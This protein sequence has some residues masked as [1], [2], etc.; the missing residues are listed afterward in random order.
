MVT[1]T[2]LT[3]ST[4]WESSHF[5]TEVKIS[6]YTAFLFGRGIACPAVR[7]VLSLQSHHLLHWW[8]TS[9]NEPQLQPKSKS[10]STHHH[11]QLPQKLKSVEQVMSDVAGSDLKNL[12]LL[13]TWY[14]CHI[15]LLKH[16]DTSFWWYWWFCDVCVRKIRS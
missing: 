7:S 15:M 4:T 14:V 12:R 6:F 16:L 11:F 2:S 13:T 8:V 10:T 9:T 5:W 1:Q 3:L